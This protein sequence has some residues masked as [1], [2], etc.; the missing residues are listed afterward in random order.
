MNSTTARTAISP[1]AGVARP[2]TIPLTVMTAA[3]AT[4][5][6]CT[7]PVTCKTG[8]CLELCK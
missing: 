1:V 8:G 2:V 3:P 6:G 7:T 5:R 4:A